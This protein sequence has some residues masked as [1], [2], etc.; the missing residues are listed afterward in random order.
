MATGLNYRYKHSKYSVGISIPLIQK[1]ASFLAMA[2]IRTLLF[3]MKGLLRCFL[4]IGGCF[5]CEM[6]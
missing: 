5:D 2:I 1:L 6:S 4:I 3:L